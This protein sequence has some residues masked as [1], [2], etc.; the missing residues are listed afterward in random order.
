M[1]THK[2]PTK[3]DNDTLPLLPKPKSNSLRRPNILLFIPLLAITF[4]YALLPL[5]STTGHKM[6]PS[7]GSDRYHGRILT[8]SNYTVV[9]GLFKQSDPDFKD[10]GY[11]LLG[12]SFGLIDKGPERWRNFERS[13]P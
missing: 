8:V 12:D 1:K 13:V 11:D 6:D 3:S 9:Q 5:S 7:R 2:R 4:C 10:G